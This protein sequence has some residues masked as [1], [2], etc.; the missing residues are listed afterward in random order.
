MPDSAACPV[1][2]D[3]DRRAEPGELCTCGRPAVV[4]Y[5]S[6]RWGAVGY[7]GLS[8][9]RPLMPCPFCGSP[10]PHPAKCPSY[11][12]NPGGATA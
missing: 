11:R 1:P 5:L 7:C 4:V 2:Y 3:A 8:G 9:V 10:E 6:E 12:L